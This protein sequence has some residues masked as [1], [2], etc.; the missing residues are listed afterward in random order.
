MNDHDVGSSGSETFVFFHVGQDVR[1]PTMLTHSIRKTNRNAQIIQ[2]SDRETQK[3]DGVDA[4]HRDNVNPSS[5]MT[6]RLQGFSNLRLVEPAIYLDTDMLVLKAIRVRE[7][8][9]GR[10]VSFCAR[11]FNTSGAF[12]GNQR[13]IDFTEYE[14]RPLGEVYPYVAC[15]TVTESYTVWEELL[16]VLIRLDPKYAIWYGDQEAM[17]IWCRSRSGQFST[18]TEAEYGCLPEEKSHLPSCKIVHFKGQ[19]RKSLMTRLYEKMNN[20]AG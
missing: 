18:H 3:V 14:G 12:I 1:L 7:L 6:A 20:T 9:C 19:A 11:S 4:I 16:A 8:L 13:G 2:C 17:K 5:L 15:S 10:R